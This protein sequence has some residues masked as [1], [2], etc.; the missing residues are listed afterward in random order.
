M[1]SRATDMALPFPTIRVRR[2][3][4]DGELA[5]RFVVCVQTGRPDFK[6]ALS[7]SLASP[8][9][10][11]PPFR[12][13][14]LFSNFRQGRRD[15]MLYPQLMPDS[16]PWYPYIERLEPH[17]DLAGPITALVFGREHFNVVEGIFGQIDSALLDRVDREWQVIRDEFVQLAANSSHAMRVPRTQ[18]RVCDLLVHSLKRSVASFARAGQYFSGIQRALADLQ[19]FV[20]YRQG[21]EHGSY[22][23]VGYELDTIGGFS[24]HIEHVKRA[25]LDGCSCWWLTNK[26][27]NWF[28]YENYTPEFGEWWPL[29]NFATYEQPFPPHLLNEPDFPDTPLSRATTASGSIIPRDM[30]APDALLAVTRNELNT[31]PRGRSPAREMPLG[32]AT[33]GRSSSSHRYRSRSRSRSRSPRGSRHRGRP[34]SRSPEP[35]QASY[36]NWTRYV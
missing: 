31:R 2:K 5:L 10:L 24:P 36:E 20:R 16:G 3:R 18:Q 25:Y 32:R 19:A 9:P 34:V 22:E 17:S 27:E 33:S 15:C 1:L 4:N 12:G 13:D 21:V 11:L 30:T 29:Y 6:F 7:F 8:P 28:G 26:L 23:A 35:V 14:P